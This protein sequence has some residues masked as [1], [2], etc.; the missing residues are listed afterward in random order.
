MIEQTGLQA[1]AV[2]AEAAAGQHAIAAIG[3]ESEA[4]FINRELSWLDRPT[5]ASKGPV[6]GRARAGLGPGC[7]GVYS[8][9][10]SKTTGSAGS[11]RS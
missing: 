4:R 8:S 9:S 10:W 5:D 7:S 3:Q 6:S 1:S 11:A 2:S